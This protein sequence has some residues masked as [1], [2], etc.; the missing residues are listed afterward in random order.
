M[1]LLTGATGNIIDLYFFNFLH[2]GAPCSIIDVC[3][4]IFLHTGASGSIIDVLSDRWRCSIESISPELPRPNLS[5]PVTAQGRSADKD[6]LGLSSPSTEA[7][8]E[9]VTGVEIPAATDQSEHQ[10]Q[11]ENGGSR[12]ISRRIRDKRQRS[13]THRRGSDVV[14]ETVS[15]NACIKSEN[16]FDGHQGDRD[17][18]RVDLNCSGMT[19]FYETFL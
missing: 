11:N 15:R 12:R 5:R 1:L 9:R 8:E 18:E 6:Q 19:C 2:V 3:F 17:S 13:S 14:A 7:V 10:T 16:T 4:L